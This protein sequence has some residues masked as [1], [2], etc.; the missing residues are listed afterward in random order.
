MRQLPHWICEADSIFHKCE[1]G[2]TAPHIG[3][4][5]RTNRLGQNGQTNPLSGVKCH[6]DP[7]C[8]SNYFSKSNN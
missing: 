6:I 5:H 4:K 1:G 2:H 3:S 8:Q 7:D